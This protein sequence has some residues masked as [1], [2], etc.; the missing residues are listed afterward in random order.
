MIFITETSD[1]NSTI[2]QVIP[3]HLTLLKAVGDTVTSGDLL[4]SL[5]SAIIPFILTLIMMVLLTK[6]DTTLRVNGYLCNSSLMKAM[7]NRLLVKAGR[8]TD[9]SQTTPT[10]GKITNI[11]DDASGKKTVTLQPV[12]ENQP[13]LTLT[14]PSGSQLIVEVGDVV[15]ANEELSRM[16]SWPFYQPPQQI[17]LQITSRSGQSTG[18]SSAQRAVLIGLLAKSIATK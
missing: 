4:T 14:I 11:Q 9:G 17:R 2:T 8:W 7:H 16:I 18:H 1:S 6:F 13:E 3:A 12:D 5:D 15:E 10:A